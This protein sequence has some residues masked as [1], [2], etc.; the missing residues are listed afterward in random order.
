TPFEAIASICSVLVVGL[1]ILTFLGQNFVIPSG[2]MEKTLLIGDH[3]VVD[4]IT[5]APPTHWAPFVHYRPVQRGDIIVFYKPVPQADGSHPFLV[6]R[7]IGIPG[8]R[9][10]LRNGIVYLNGIAQNEPYAAKP[11]VAAYDSYVDDFPSVSPA[12]RPDVTATWAVSLAEHIQKD[13]LV[14]PAG[15]YF[16]MGDNRDRSLDS[17]FW[18]FVPRENIIGRS[19]FVYWSFEA[20]ENNELKP[21]ISEQLSSTANEILH[22]FDKTR[23]R[24]TLHRVE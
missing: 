17:R 8:D 14:V 23:W 13:D 6:K 22:F 21:S 10:H 11:S 24:R 4:R 2:S 7:V 5:L 12:E 19:L 20:P 3:V 16:V 15:N 1:F 9:I 18:G